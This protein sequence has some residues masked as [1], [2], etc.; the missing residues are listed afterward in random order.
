MMLGL[1]VPPSKHPFV[2]FQVWVLDA[3]LEKCRE[4]LDAR[5]LNEIP[6]C[7]D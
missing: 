3:D 2:G 6:P 1:P 5:P 7:S 4:I